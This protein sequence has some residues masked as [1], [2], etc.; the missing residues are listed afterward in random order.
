M[1]PRDSGQKFDPL[2]LVIMKCTV[3]YTC[4]D[5]VALSLSVSAV[6]AAATGPGLRAR[7]LHSLSLRRTRSSRITKAATLGSHRHRLCLVEVFHQRRL[8]RVGGCATRRRRAASSSRQPLH[9]EVECR[10]AK[11]VRQRQQRCCDQQA[12]QHLR[13]CRANTVH[14]SQRTGRSTT[15]KRRPRGRTVGAFGRFPAN[16]SLPTA[17]TVCRQVHD[18]VGRHVPASTANAEDLTIAPQGSAAVHTTRHAR[19]SE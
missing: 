17:P 6:S 13:A 11:L 15:W 4:A 7:A 14:H 12:D 8:F 16:G 1:P 10:R 18:I 2:M 9:G 5:V 19:S 3:E